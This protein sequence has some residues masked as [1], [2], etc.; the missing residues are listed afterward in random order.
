MTRLKPDKVEHDAARERHGL[1][2]IARAGAARRHRDAEVEGGG[3]RLRSTS[4]SLA[5]LTTMSAV[6]ASS[7]RFSTGEYQ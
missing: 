7:W 6:T 5:G 1:A 2:V 4:A 3:E